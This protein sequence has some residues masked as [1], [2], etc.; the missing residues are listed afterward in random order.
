MPV[1]VTGASGFLGGRLAEV[2]ARRGEQVTVLARTGSDLRHLSEF[3]G[4]RVKVVRGSLTDNL[5]VK[6]AVREATH[7]FHCAAASTDWALPEVYL[8]SNVKGTEML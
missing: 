2:L 3:I 6:K 7:V 4:S 5:A 1:L 8:E